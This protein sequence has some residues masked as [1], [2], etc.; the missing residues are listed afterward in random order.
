VPRLRENFH[1]TT[2]ASVASAVDYLRRTPVTCQFVISDVRVN[3]EETF[4]FFRAAKTLTSA[5]TIL[6]TTS[7][8]ARVPEALLSGGDAILLK[9]FEPNLLF[10]RLG[11]LKQ[12]RLDKYDLAGTR[13]F[14]LNERRS[15]AIGGEIGMALPHDYC[16]HCNASPITCFDFVGSRRAWF[17]CLGCKQVWIAKWMN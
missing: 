1:V 6:V 11:R 16:P 9:P 15:A 12:A 3:G 17:A 8:V 4:D 2:T 13:A 10:A 7:D 5:P 14:Q